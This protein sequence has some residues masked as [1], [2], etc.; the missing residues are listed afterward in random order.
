VKVST[1]LDEGLRVLRGRIG[2]MKQHLK[3]QM[4]VK[5]REGAKK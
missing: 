4:M 3:Q 2:L 5:L 1:K